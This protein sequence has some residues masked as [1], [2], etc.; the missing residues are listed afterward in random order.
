[1]SEVRPRPSRLPPAPEPR[2]FKLSYRV[3][4]ALAIPMLVVAV[5][6]VSTVRGYLRTR[7]SVHALSESIFAQVA[8]QTVARTQGYLD[9]AVPALDVLVALSEDEQRAEGHDS[10]L[11]RR[12][13]ATLRA[14]PSFT[15]VSYGDERGAFS[16]AYRA[17]PGT[18]RFNHSVIGEDGR[19]ALDEHDLRDDGTR[20]LFRH[21]DDSGYD[22]RRRPWY[23]VARRSDGHAWTAPY[24]FY[25]RHVPGISC[26][27]ALRGRGAGAA[28][29]GVYSVDFELDALSRFVAQLKPSQNSVVFVYTQEG[30]VLAHPTL[31]VVERGAEP[32]LVR[33]ADVRD[34]ALQAFRAALGR[35][36]VDA[37]GHRH[38][39]FAVRGAT[40]LASVARLPV[41]G[42]LEWRVGVLA[43][44]LDFMGDVERENRASLAL[45]AASVALAVLFA[46]WLA[47]R[48]ARP[49][50]ELRAEMDRVGEFRLEERPPV[51][52]VFKEIDAMGRA[53]AQMKSGLASFARFVPRD[54]VRKML[55]AGREAELG[56][57]VRELTV[58]F[59]DLA[60][61]TTLAE[62][63]EPDALVRTL[64][65]YFEAMT[66]T[67]TA[68]GGTVDK[69][70]GD[71]IM[72]FWNA[73]LEDPAHA[74]RACLAALACQRA[75]EALARD[76]EHAWVANT[77]TR[78]GIATGPVVV[79]NIGTSE[80]MNYTAMGDAVNLSARLESLNKQYGTLLMASERT[81]ALAG[82][83]VLSRAVDVVAVK[84]KARGVKVYELLAPALDAT[85]AQRSLAAL[86]DEA[87][88]RYLDL[89]FMGAIERWSRALELVP[90]DPVATRMRARAERYLREPPPP[91]WDGVYVAKDK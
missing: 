14:N 24:I 45:G 55:A 25:N 9:N 11:G 57:E 70:I 40:H 32:R 22:P 20:P 80:R 89:D 33:L 34:P 26:V 65:G 78:I 64:G 81:I 68:H 72:S 69:Y 91:D 87:L 7:A 6:G 5:G 76:P 67:L 73:P 86:C 62:S 15:W 85:E 27:R 35:G 90:E 59:S 66:D 84:G 19:T 28:V 71:G 10:V 63:M 79:G 48:V 18:L 39:R 21:Q 1:M 3:S 30:E 82:D 4:L 51:R 36:D 13:I 42:A 16:G 41:E 29:R 50:A 83:A 52:S 54:L 17:E 47:T 49:V 46:L 2:R 75:L 60:G 88:D 58:V 53:L 12:V 38:F 74:R 31:S 8:A 77:G 37:A 43:P 23:A 44:E 61:F 56:G